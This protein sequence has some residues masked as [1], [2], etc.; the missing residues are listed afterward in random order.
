LLP[1]GRVP[2][3]DES[4]PLNEVDLDPFFLSKFELTWGQWT[5]I[6]PSWTGHGGPTDDPVQPAAFISWGDCQEF[7]GRL[8]GW[9]RLPSEAQWEYGCR[10]GTTTRW[11]TGAD[12]G[13]LQGAAWFGP[14]VSDTS[15]PVGTLRANPFGLHDVH[16]NLLEWCQDS[17]DRNVH[18][19]SRDGL[20]DHS[21]AARRVSR[22]GSF[23]ASANLAASSNSSPVTPGMRS[24]YW[25][26]RAA[27]IITP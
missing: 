21:A 24:V 2:V 4:R 5:R 15:L 11:W 10:A 16:G 17:D 8:P 22:G 26:V 12:K 1:G 18:P 27:S 9:L 20:R 6:A 25:G 13:T 3:E 14:K 23:H 19:R 7:L